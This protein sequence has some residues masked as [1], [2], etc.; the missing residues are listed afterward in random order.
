[1]NRF[2][3]DAARRAAEVES[4]FDHAR[5]IVVPGLIWAAAILVAILGALIQPD[6]GAQRA[7]GTVPTEAATVAYGA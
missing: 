3:H 2:P 5:Y 7:A 6:A 1:M 4:E